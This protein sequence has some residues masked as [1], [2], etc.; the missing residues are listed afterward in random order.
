MAEYYTC[1]KYDE[2]WSNAFY[3]ALR[4]VRCAATSAHNVQ[5]YKLD[6]LILTVPPPPTSGASPCFLGISSKLG[7]FIFFITATTAEF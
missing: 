2:A 7:F 3:T 1:D 6:C 4:E 5:R